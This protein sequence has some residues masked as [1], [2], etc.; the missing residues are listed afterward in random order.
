M[1]NLNKIQLLLFILFATLLQGC[2]LPKYEIRPGDDY[3]RI[4]ISKLKND[5]IMC[6][7]D[8]SYALWPQP[9]VDYALVPANRKISIAKNI[10]WSSGN[11]HYSC[12][13]RVKFS[14]EKDIHYS[15][16]YFFK[17][18][19]CAMFIFKGSNDPNTKKILDPT[20]EKS[21]CKKS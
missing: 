19:K 17:N 11:Y 16:Q 4:D 2:F 18:N 5:A 10:V 3:A 8:K 15:A 7:D 20:L 21:F 13:A 14:P 1:L 9:N 12:F 6:V